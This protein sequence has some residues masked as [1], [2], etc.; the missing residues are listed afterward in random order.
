MCVQRRHHISLSGVWRRL[1]L[2]VEVLLA[3]EQTLIE[4]GRLAV[5]EVHVSGLEV[6]VVGVEDVVVVVVVEPGWAVVLVVVGAAA[7]GWWTGRSGVEIEVDT[8]GKT[9]TSRHMS[10]PYLLLL[11]AFYVLYLTTY[12]K[13]TSFW[14]TTFFIPPL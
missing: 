4:D 8:G 3:A 12:C 9:L 13:T 1:S 2:W 11:F 6:V 5:E 10:F 14:K 7:A